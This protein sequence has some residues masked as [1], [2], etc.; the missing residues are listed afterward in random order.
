MRKLGYLLALLLVLA[1]CQSAAS[2]RATFR[3]PDIQ[4]DPNPLI[5]QGPAGEIFRFV[6]TG[7]TTC[8]RYSMADST[9]PAGAGPM[10]HIHHWTDEW[11]YFP[12]GGIVIYMSDRTYPDLNVVPGYQAPKGRVH[13]Y[14]TKPGDLVYGPRH[15]IHGFTNESAGTRRLIFVWTP[16]RITDYFREVGQTVTDVN[17]LPPI[18]ERNKQLFVSQAPKYG[19][20]QSSRFDEYVSGADDDLHPMDNRAAEL[21]ALLANDIKGQVKP[22]K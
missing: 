12:D 10:P 20:N 21:Q 9:I 14:H 11:F 4:P 17:R 1:G 13:R 7:A 8:G 19:I 15:Y 22:C 16:D 6:K 2:R 18:A 5:I 3:F